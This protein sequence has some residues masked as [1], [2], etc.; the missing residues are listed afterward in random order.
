M[1]KKAK[2]QQELAEKDKD[3]DKDYWSDMQ[4]LKDRSWDDWKDLNE[5]GAGNKM[6]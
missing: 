5:K 4:T 1:M 2:E 6:K 3:D